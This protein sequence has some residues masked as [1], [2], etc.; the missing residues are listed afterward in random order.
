MKKFPNP[1]IL[2]ENQESK[3]NEGVCRSQHEFQSKTTESHL[4]R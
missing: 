1:T 4:K 3:A 2:S